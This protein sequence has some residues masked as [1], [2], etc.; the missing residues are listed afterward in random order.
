[1][2]KHLASK[3]WFSIVSILIIASQMSYGNSDLEILSEKSILYREIMPIATAWKDAVLKKD[4]EVMVSYALPE[5]QNYVRDNL[6]KKGSNLYR[7]FY[8]SGWNQQKGRRSFY[9]ILKSAKH[10]K[11]LIARHKS[12]EKYGSGVSVYYYDEDKIKP[13]FPLAN[14][15]LQLLMDKGYIVSMFFFKTEGRWYI[16]YEFEEE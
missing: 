15:E 2:Q 3:Y 12:L 1:M 14:E 16:S 13:K 11:I 9:D 6:K 8:D 5:A 7:L 10:L 4:I